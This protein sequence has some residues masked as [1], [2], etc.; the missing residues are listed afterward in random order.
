MCHRLKNTIIHLKLDSV[1][2]S[3]EMSKDWLWKI[4]FMVQNIFEK[5]QQQQQRSN[6]CAIQAKTI[7]QK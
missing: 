1:A 5:Q 4:L 3:V 7:Q 6:S 2:V